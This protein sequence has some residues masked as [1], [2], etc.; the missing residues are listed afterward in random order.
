[1]QMQ[2]EVTQDDIDSGC[3][4]DSNNCA[5]ARAIIRQVPHVVPQSVLVDQDE[6]RFQ[7]HGPITGLRTFCEETPPTVASFIELYDKL[8]EHREADGDL[9]PEPITFELDLSAWSR[10]VV[11]S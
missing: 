1:M 8:P 9:D 3:R 7:T 5:V 11:E 6:I 10:G 2:I 4:E